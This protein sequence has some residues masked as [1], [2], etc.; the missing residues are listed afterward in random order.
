MLNT[1]LMAAGAII[2]V[3]FWAYLAWDSHQEVRAQ[4]KVDSKK[5][6]PR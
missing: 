3:C 2:F 1:L 4:V 5:N 6:T